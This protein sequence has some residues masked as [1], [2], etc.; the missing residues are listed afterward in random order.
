MEKEDK[1]EALVLLNF[2]SVKYKNRKIHI[3]P[4]FVA[5][6]VETEDPEGLS[7]VIT[8]ASGESFE[9]RDD[10]RDAVKRINKNSPVENR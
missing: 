3:N 9:V 10:G 4:A 8:L 6:V 7:A 2:D 1:A 5:M